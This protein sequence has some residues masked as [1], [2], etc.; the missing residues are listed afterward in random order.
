MRHLR[1]ALRRLAH[2]HRAAPAAPALGCVEPVAQP[3][4]GWA[5]LEAERLLSDDEIGGAFMIGDDVDAPPPV[6]SE[7]ESIIRERER[8]YA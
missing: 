7:M 4:A 8:R 1:R 3:H 2:A 6:I 5:R